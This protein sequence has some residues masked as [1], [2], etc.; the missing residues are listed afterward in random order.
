MLFSLANIVNASV[1]INEVQISP[2]ENRFIELYNSGDSKIDL[3]GWYIQRK[4]VN[5]TSFGSLVSKTYFDGVNIEANGY[6]LISKIPLDNSDIVVDNLTLTKSNSIQIKNSNRDIIDTV[7]WEDI[8]D[9]KSSQRNSSQKWVTG[10]PTP[11]EPNQDIKSTNTNSNSVSNTGVSANTVYGNSTV[12]IQQNLSVRKITAKIIVSRIV[13]AK[14]PLNI[15]PL[16][17]TNKG[18]TLSKGNFQWNFGDGITSEYNN[19]KEFQHTYFYPGEYV[20]L[21]NYS[22]YKKPKPDA[23]IRFIIKI[24]PSKVFISSVGSGKDSFIELENKSSHEIA[25]SDWVITAGIN[26]FSIPTGTILLANEKLKFSPQVTGFNSN[27]LKFIALTNP[28]GEIMT[29]YPVQT[30]K[31]KSLKKQKRKYNFSSSTTKIIKK[32]SKIIDLNNL[33][34]SAGNAN[35]DIPMSVYPYLGLAGIIIIGMASVLLLKK[36]DKSSH[37]FEEKI[38]AEDI[39]IIE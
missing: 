25:L 34:A 28:K 5:G 32:D 23:S 38:R 9:G 35:K 20:I 36:K 6:L 19:S 11:G 1:V 30:Q 3:T 21:L 39:T 31:I 16:I 24:I 14:T 37:Y 12:Q 15:K 26:R 13:F 18:E 29:V 2:V 4:T 27:N 10:S 8:S 22:E 33:S 17:T 7:T